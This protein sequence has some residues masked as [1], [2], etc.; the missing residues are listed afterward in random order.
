MREGGGERRERH[1]G[2]PATYSST[3]THPLS[4]STFVCVCVCIHTYIH[5]YKQ[6]YIHTYLPTYI[7]TYTHTHTH[8]YIHTYIHT[9]KSGSAA[10]VT[11]PATKSGLF[12]ATRREI[13]P[14]TPLPT[15]ITGDLVMRRSIRKM[16][17]AGVCVCVCVCV[18]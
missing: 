6:T 13:H 5:T 18:G 15:R 12:S 9:V 8:T 7:H 1:E 10:I 16:V 4:T 14:P 3:N 17:S 11:S 2:V